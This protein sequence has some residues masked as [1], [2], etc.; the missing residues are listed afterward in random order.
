M[1]RQAASSS[2]AAGSALDHPG[3]RN[4]EYHIK[5]KKI[6]TVLAV[7]LSFAFVA[8]AAD[9]P[10]M[11]AF[12]G[13]S[14]VRFNPDSA[15]IP[16]FNAN[17][18]NGQFVYN[19]WK[20]LG[21]AVDAGAVNKGTLNGFNVDTTV[22]DFVAGPRYTIHRGRVAPFVQ[23]LFGGSHATTSAQFISFP[24]LNAIAGIPVPGN[25]PVTSRVSASHTGFAMLAGGGVDIKFGKHMAFR[26]AEFDYYLTRIPSFIIS[27]ERNRNNWRYSA[28][29][30]FLFG[31]R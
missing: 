20:G 13:Y 28:G 26:P 14:F 7:S 30:N 8:G 27:E 3:I 19:F 11:E 1:P 25:L 24:I 4:E 23:A 18:G 17:G 15:F 6:F 10:K 29:V 2:Q 22:I 5:M 9:N 31:E 21:A 12:L 16:S